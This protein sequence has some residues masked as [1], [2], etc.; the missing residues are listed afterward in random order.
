[1]LIHVDDGGGPI[2]HTLIKSQT[3]VN[4][5]F[6]SVAMD[7]T[8]KILLLVLRTTALFFAIQYQK[9]NS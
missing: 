5:F 6:L 7:S 1:M 2:S 9:I 8:I 3:Y 4:P